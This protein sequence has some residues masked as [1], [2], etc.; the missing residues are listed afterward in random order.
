M[1][2]RRARRP[3][4]LPYI[5]V[6][7]RRGLHPLRSRSGRTGLAGENTPVQAGAK[8]GAN[9]EEQFI[10]GSAIDCAE[11]LTR[12][13]DELGMTHFV[14]KPHWRGLPHREAMAQLEGFGTK[15]LSVVR[16]S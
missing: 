3:T 14:Y 9:I 13:R 1:T 4:G 10:L 6:C 5:E 15:V 2:Q 16:G 8:L 11:E 12:L 7:T